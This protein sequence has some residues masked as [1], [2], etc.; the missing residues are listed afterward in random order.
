[1]PVSQEPVLSSGEGGGGEGVG[2][3]GGGEGGCAMGAGEAGDGGSGT[4]VSTA[5]SKK[6]T[7]DHPAAHKIEA[8]AALGG[9]RAR[10]RLGHR[11]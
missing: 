7:C 1:M 8:Q 3:R 4:A 2:G 10:S 6:T 11:F 5:S 9:H